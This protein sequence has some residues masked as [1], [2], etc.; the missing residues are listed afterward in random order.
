[1]PVLRLS[2]LAEADLE[3]I[4]D[5]IAQDNPGAAAAFI[6]QIIETCTLLA[7]SPKIGRD[8]SNLRPNTRSFPVGRY[9]VFFQMVP[10]G[11]EVLRVLHGARDIRWL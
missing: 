3:Q 1:M 4:G 2:R 9:V 6:M 5:Y 11:I 10:G 7:G 8:R